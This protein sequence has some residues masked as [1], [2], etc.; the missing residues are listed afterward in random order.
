[1][2]VY[3]IDILAYLLSIEAGMVGARPRLRWIRHIFT[4]FI[5]MEQRYMVADSEHMPKHITSEETW[6]VSYSAKE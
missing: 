4:G 1:M 3:D 6:I 2:M 5:R